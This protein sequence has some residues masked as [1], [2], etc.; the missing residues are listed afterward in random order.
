MSKEIEI[1][2]RDEDT[3][4]EDSREKTHFHTTLY[5]DLYS[6]VKAAAWHEQTSISELM[7]H[8]VEEGIADL[9]EERGEE[10]TVHPPHKVE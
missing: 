5:K 7:N 2:T 10:Y 4:E 8:I 1:N 9:E 3:H 6:K